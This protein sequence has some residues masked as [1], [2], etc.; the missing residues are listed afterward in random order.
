MKTQ[1]SRLAIAK[2]VAVALAAFA[3]A[4][5]LFA[6]APAAPPPVTSADGKG[7]EAIRGMANEN[8]WTEVMKAA[9]KF[10]GQYKDASPFSR[11]VRYYLALAYL[12]QDK[13]QDDAVREFRKLLTDPK[14]TPDV[15]EQAQM[16]IAKAF[17]LKGIGLPDGTD[18]QRKVRN[19]IFDEA[20]KGYDAYI[21]A[22]P[23]SRSGDTAYFLSGI[24]AL[25]VK[26][27]E[28]AVKRFGTVF[29]N[30]TQ[31][32]LRSDAILN[33][34]KAHLIQAND[35]MAAA[36]GKEPKPEDIQ[37]ALDIF[38]KNAIPTLTQ[39]FKSSTDLAI[40]NEAQFYIGQIRLT[41]S[42][43]INEPDKEKLKARRA[44][45]LNP[46][47]DAFRAV[48][49]IEEVVAAQDAK[50]KALEDAITRLPPGTPEYL[51]YRSYY[52][53]LISV[54]SDKREKLKTGTD[55]YLSARIAI[56]RIFMSLEK[57]D[58]AR[59]LVRYLVGLKELFAK[60]KES[61][62]AVNAILCDTYVSQNNV[63]KGMETYEAFRAAFK[64]NEAGEHLPLTVANM[65]VNAGKPDKAEEIVNQGIED[66]KAAHNN[67]GWQFSSDAVRILIKVA[68]DKG[69]YDKALTLCDKVLAG[70][71][72]P[73][74]EAET[75][76]IKGTIQEQMALSKGS[77]ALSDQAMTTFQLVRD[78]FGTSPK[79]E[80]AWFRQCQILAG[81]AAL[82]KADAPK[83]IGEISKYIDTFSGGSGKSEDTK[84]NVATATYVLGKV[85]DGAEQTDKAIT[86]FRT[87][88]DKYPENEVTPDA[89][90]RIVDIENRRK[91]WAG[92]KKAMEEFLVKYPTHKNAYYAFNNIADILFSGALNT[93]P[94]P[95]GKPMQAAATSADR[96]AG[97]KKLMEYVD[98]EL[99]K[100][101]TPPKGES[102]L[103]KVADTW[104][105]QLSTL[106]NN[107]D[108]LPKEKKLDWQT[109]VDNVLGAVEKQLKSYPAGDRLPEALDRAVKVQTAALAARQIDA[110]KGESYFRDLATKY[111]ATNE[112]KSKILMSL[113]SFLETADAKKSASAR[114]EAAKLVPEAVKKQGTDDKGQPTG[115][116]SIQ[117]SFLPQDW[118]RLIGDLFDQKKFDEMNKQIARVRV[119]YPLGDAPSSL[120]QDAQA[121]CLFWEGKIL[122]EQ[123]KITDAGA[124]FAELAKLYPTST[125]RMEADYGIIAGKRT[126]GQL[127][128]EI[129]QRLALKRLGE[130]VGVS[131]AKTFDL[132]AKALLLMG[133]INEDLKDYD[134]AIVAY[135]KVAD[136]FA[137]VPKVASEGL[138]RAA[139][140]LEKQAAN[141]LPVRLPAEKA[142]AAKKA[143][144]L[145]DAH[146]KAEDDKKAATD[147]KAAGGKPG[148][149][150]PADAKPGDKK[151]DAAK[152]ADKTTAAATEKK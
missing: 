7:A 31:S 140:L 23:K 145:M 12:R 141:Q 61:E 121:V 122:E 51:N 133:Q 77:P 93:K 81:K 2:A 88:I 144:D 10:L 90:F 123:G 16:L 96:E 111:G 99:E 11:E 91:N 40:L 33:M 126:A 113:A 106:G 34:G 142:S 108:L 44:E 47:L 48:R 1:P 80:D 26:R 89:Y 64:G 137:S 20:I 46:A 105:K 119:E 87:M 120:V 71:P 32:P 4:P 13:M 21:Q 132:Q 92:V 8:K 59:V 109:S 114:A 62:A 76:Y 30:Y 58:E 101:I 37:R 68:L 29:Q 129:D 94:G 107:F 139:G 27:Y 85:Y 24:L 70:A 138:W 45:L 49:S 135:A 110:A 75:L 125:K 134:N 148:E 127:K 3:P 73:E 151:P 97:S 150:K 18:A 22:Y 14:I 104:L 143:K 19:D 38:E 9:E 79:A 52:E 146:K 131:K 117:P 63:E 86:T 147:P 102:A 50:I 54:E 56:A 116:E 28:D 66:Y 98:Y 130:I 112:A 84:N 65:L 100:K 57:Y 41:Q 103:L 5:L 115:T 60:D 42:I 67:G 15:K 78:K 83:A 152:P 25:E 43:Q 17:T 35:L 74:I 39:V 36:P 124:K 128:E 95:D 6:Q 72:K 53:N 69:D 55:Q 118:D 149:A 82:S 136:F